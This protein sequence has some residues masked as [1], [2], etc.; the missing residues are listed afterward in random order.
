MLVRFVTAKPQWELPWYHFWSFFFA[1]LLKYMQNLSTSPLFPPPFPTLPVA[2]M[3]YTIFQASDQTYTTAATPATE[4]TLG[5]VP[6]GNSS[7]HHHLNPGPH[8]VTG[9]TRVSQPWH[10]WHLWPV[11]LWEGVDRPVHCRML[12]SISSLCPLDVSNSP[13]VLT[14]KN[15]RRHC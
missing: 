5:P 10:C 3:A 2:P 13:T 12:G 9:Y 7:P 11:V 15:V 4:V 14:T 6:Q 1:L 8:S